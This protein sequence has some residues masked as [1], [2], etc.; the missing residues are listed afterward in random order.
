MPPAGLVL[1]TPVSIVGDG[2]IA[3]AS[4]A[5]VEIVIPITLTTYVDVVESRPTIASAIVPTTITRV[6]TVNKLSALF[7]PVRFSPASA[8]S[9]GHRV[10]R[11]AKSHEE[12]HCHNP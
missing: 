5:T 3:I 10:V 9:L 12:T 1:A 2:A 11:Y 6:M 8:S 4:S 7:I